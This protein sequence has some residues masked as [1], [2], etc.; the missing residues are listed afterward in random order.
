MRSVDG[1]GEA[2]GIMISCSAR[3]LEQ[4]AEELHMVQ[5]MR[6]QSTRDHIMSENGR[7]QVSYIW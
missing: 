1:V 5:S 3:Q 6:H 4:T 7:S 2:K